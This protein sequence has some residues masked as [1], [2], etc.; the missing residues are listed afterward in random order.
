MAKIGLK[1]MCYRGKTTQGIIGKAIQ[2]DISITSNN[3]TLFAEDAIAESD[4]SFQS[5]SITIGIDDLSDVIQADMLGHTVDA[6]T[7]EIVANRADIAP[8]V[9][10]GFYATKLVNNVK[11]FRAIF[12]NKVQ[13]AEPN[14]TNTTRGE[15]VTFNTPTLEGTIMTLDN[16]NWKS[17]QTFATEAEAITYLNT[18]AGITPEV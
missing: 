18:K 9:G 3:V 13:F 15:N 6:V 1:M 12:L 7:G 17:E 4:K 11:K 2:A 14:D 16:G 5:G 8:Y 10:I